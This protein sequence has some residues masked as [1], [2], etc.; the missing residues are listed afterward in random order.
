MVEFIDVR[1]FILQIIDKHCLRTRTGSAVT[2]RLVVKLESDNMRYIFDML[3]DRADDTLAVETVSGMC[4][5]HILSCTVNILSVVR[6]CKNIRIL[7]CQPGRDRIGRCADND[8]DSVFCCGIQHLVKMRE[9]KYAVSWLDGAPCGLRNTDRVHSGF[10]H[11]LHVLLYTV[12]RKI[13]RV[14]G[15]TE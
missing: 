6:E 4:D 7:L 13:F 15:S 10:C 5:I 9:I 8:R 14:V 3:H 12:I 1:I 2:F 11:H